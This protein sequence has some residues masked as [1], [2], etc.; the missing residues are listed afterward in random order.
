MAVRNFYSSL[1]ILAVAAVFVV[2]QRVDGVR[3]V[4]PSVDSAVFK[5]NAADVCSR[6]VDV[7]GCSKI[8][9][10]MCSERNREY[11]AKRG[12]NCSQLLSDH[13]RHEPT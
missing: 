10:I 13:N 9:A 12:I 4:L 11:S 3:P 1:F 8:L 5:Q 6:A 2:A 7:E